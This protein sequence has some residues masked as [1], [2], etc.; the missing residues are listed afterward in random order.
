M[1]VRLSVMMFL[2][3]AAQGAFIPVHGAYLRELGF[4]ADEIAWVCSTT[5]LGSLLG[6]LQLAQ[7]ADRWL[8]ADRCVLICSLVSGTL[9]WFAADL[10][11]PMALFWTELGIMTFLVPLNSLGPA[12]AFRHLQHAD[13]DF[14]TVRMWG[15]IGWMAGGYMLTLWFMFG[16]IPH[17]GLSDSL[18]LGGIFAWILAAYSLTLPATPPLHSELRREGILGALH[19]LVDAPLAATGLFRQRAFCVY[20][21]CFFG[22]YVTWSFNLQLTEPAPQGPRHPREVAVDGADVRADDRGRDPVDAAVAPAPAR[23][24]AD[25]DRRHH[26]VGDR[27]VCA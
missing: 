7:V 19:R 13:R 26:G 5:A 4:S 3:Y 18:R 24:A 1:V 14:G 11:D 15:T 2:G 12:L 9:L 6:P 25:D 23:P 8:S 16:G 20:V 22:A 17:H 21:V 27:A 10:R